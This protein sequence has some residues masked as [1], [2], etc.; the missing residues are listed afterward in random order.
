MV[1]AGT[2][3]PLLTAEQ[4][5]HA[6]RAALQA[7]RQEAEA[8]HHKDLWTK[9][10]HGGPHRKVRARAAG[11]QSK[12]VIQQGIL[13]G[14]TCIICGVYRHV[15][16]HMGGGSHQATYRTQQQ[17]GTLA[18]VQMHQCTLACRRGSADAHAVHRR[19]SRIM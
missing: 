13:T 4:A 17:M 1:P 12:D 15:V 5:A 18:R 11:A 9:D 3:S 2:G 7:R 19:G 8:H 14:M 16:G 10:P 6:R